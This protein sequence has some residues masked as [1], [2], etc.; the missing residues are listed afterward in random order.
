MVFYFFFYVAKIHE[1]KLKKKF[2]E[3]KKAVSLRPQN[4]FQFSIDCFR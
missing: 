2:V 4:H 3:L 1:K